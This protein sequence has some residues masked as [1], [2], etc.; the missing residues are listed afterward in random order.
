M[1]RRIP[2]MAAAAMALIALSAGAVSAKTL[3]VRS[4]GPS[5]KSYP[6]GKA[7]PDTAKISLQAGDSVTV[8][9]PGAKRTLR[10]PGTFPAASASAEGLS[11]AAAK[12][13]RFG[14]MRTGDLALN[15][16]PWN[17]DV[18]QSGTVCISGSSLKMW[19]PNSEDVAKLSIK[20]PAGAATTV[21]W[22]AGKSTMDWP[23]SVKISSGTDYQIAM[24]HTASPET[25]RFAV[26]PSIPQDITD[27]AQ[28]L[29][30]NG[31]QNQLDV[32]VDGLDSAQ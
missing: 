29:I 20:G 6:P 32:L 30:K 2:H 5:A 23:A 7:L 31:C 15:P 25:V 24:A 3:V 12:R 26:L 13:T 28:E 8:L 27:A 18:T 9:S 22:P 14:A 11:Q 10:G 16:S 4:V 1:T 17:L 19:R 21:T